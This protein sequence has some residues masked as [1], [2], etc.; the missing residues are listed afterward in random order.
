MLDTAELLRLAVK[1]DIIDLDDVQ[2]RLEMKN[3]A[4]IIEMHPYAITQGKDGNWRTY[5]VDYSQKNNRRQIKKSTKEKVE[6]A[7]V[8]DYRQKAKKEEMTLEKVYPE[9]LKYYRLHTKSDG[10]VKRITCD[11]KKFYKEDSIIKQPINKLTKIQLDKWVHAKIKE[12]EMTKTCYYNMSLIIR[13]MMIYAKECGYIEKNVFAEVRVNA[14][15]FSKKKKSDSEEQVYTLEEELLLVAQAW[16]DYCNNPEVTTPLAVILIFYLGLRVGEVVALKDEDIKKDKI[17][18]R[19]MESRKF[20]TSNEI[21]YKQSGRTVVEHTK[22]SAGNREIYLVP[23]ARE[24]IDIILQQNKASGQDG[25]LF[26]VDGKRIYDT[27]IRWRVQKYCKKANIVYRSPHKIRK[28][29][30]SKLIDA[31]VNIN[32]IRELAGHEDE[33]TTYKN[34]C[35]DRKTEKQRQEQMEEALVFKQKREK[36]SNVITVCA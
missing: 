5:L 10:T 25:Y 16:E 9:W 35:Y 34:Y 13:Q 4:E 11:W 18:I 8:D 3:R 2:A 6:Q 22:S 29:W 17:V 27:A 36:S 23:E 7:I 1:N 19:R 28:T 31:K 14:K 12:Y 26:V 30:I 32:T 15:M 33:R 24:I 21:D 20:E